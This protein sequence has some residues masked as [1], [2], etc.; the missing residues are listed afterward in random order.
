MWTA[1][2][3]RIPADGGVEFTGWTPGDGSVT[4]ASV[5]RDLRTPGGAARRV[6]GPI[7]R[8]HAHFVF[9]DHVK[10]TSDPAFVDNVLHLLLEK[11]R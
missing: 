9:S 4:R 7:P 8:E 3:T 10:M 1:N 11:P 6:Y 5:L 2:R